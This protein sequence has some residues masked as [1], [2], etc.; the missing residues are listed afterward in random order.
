M[1]FCSETD[2]LLCET[3][4]L[5][6]ALA[7]VDTNAQPHVVAFSGSGTL[8][9][10]QLTCDTGTFT[11]RQ[12]GPGSLLL[13]Q[14]DGTTYTLGVANGPAAGADTVTVSRLLPGLWGGTQPANPVLT[15][16]AAASWQQIAFPQLGIV[17]ASLEEAYGVSPVDVILNP[18]ALRRACAVGA[19]AHIFRSMANFERNV[20]GAGGSAPGTAV[21]SD[22]RKLSDAYFA[23]FKLA[24]RNVRLEL[25]TNGDG[26]TDEVRRLDAPSIERLS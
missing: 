16:P 5:T 24:L 10:D 2:L 3:A 12:I 22:Y 23:T 8:T 11:Q 14:A 9:G 1:L 15:G 7:L 6:A 19:V 4:L 21:G 17:S 18:R 20:Y 13:V 26:R 25:D